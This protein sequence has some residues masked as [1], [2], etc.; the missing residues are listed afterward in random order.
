MIKSDK[1]LWF[2]LLLCV[3]FSVLFIAVP[4]LIAHNT[5]SNGLGAGVFCSHC[6]TDFRLPL[7][8]ADS[9]PPPYPKSFGFYR[10]CHPL[11]T[12]CVFPFPFPGIYPSYWHSF[13]DCYSDTVH[14][15][16][17]YIS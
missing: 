2:R 9:Y 1:S 8:Y 17:G 6:N 12:F 5:R 7:F 4:A 13:P 3:L 11:Y 10:H 14:S 16:F 15:F